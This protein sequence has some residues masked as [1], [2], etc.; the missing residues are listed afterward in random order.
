M[1]KKALEYIVGL[2]D[3]KLHTIEVSDGTHEIFSDKPLH[4]VLPYAPMASPIEM[5][6]LSS[7]VDYVRSEV[8]EMPGTMI[9]QVVDPETVDVVSALNDNRDREHLARVTASVPKFCYD[10]FH[11]HESFCIAVQSKF[12]DDNTTDKTLLLKFAGTVEQGSVAQYGDDGVS[13]KATVKQGIAS[14]SD[15]I[16]PSPVRLRPYR[17]F[18][19]VEQPASKF[20][21][22]MKQDKYEGIQC[23]L[24]QADGGA[25]ENAAKH[26]IKEYLEE[27]LEGMI[28]QGKY[29]VIS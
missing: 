20:V 23:A 4:R 9:V 8:D 13:Q 11:D 24:F 26:S 29:I 2:G 14:K 21:F 17:T 19:E 12:V 16:V 22:R 27:K 25:W 6:T 28:A 1:I 5:N 15:A 7:L 18:V 3:A 10:R